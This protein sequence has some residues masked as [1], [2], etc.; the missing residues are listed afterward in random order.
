MM[1]NRHTR[2]DVVYLG[3][4]DEME[5]TIS[6]ERMATPVTFRLQSG[7]PTEWLAIAAKAAA[8]YSPGQHDWK[9]SIRE[10]DQVGD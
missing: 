2:I 7:S 9:M 5:Y 3:D 8:D 6:D 10:A 4:S 1:V